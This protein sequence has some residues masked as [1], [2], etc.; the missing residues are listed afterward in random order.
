[1]DEL[2]IDEGFAE[3]ERAHVVE[4][5][6]EAFGRKLRPAFPDE[7]ICRKALMAT[8]RKDRFI[9]A[10]RGGKLLGICGFHQAGVGSVGFKWASLR[11]SISMLQFLRAILVLS[12]ISTSERHGAFTLDGIAEDS[13][14]RGQGVGTA[15]LDAAAAKARLAKARAVRLSV[16]NNNPR[17]RALYEREGFRQVAEGSIGTLSKFYGFREY[18]TMERDVSA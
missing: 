15:L 2:S 1:M 4:L 13:S 10:R 5:Y 18:I 16:V 14:A 6:L 3:N 17:A 9:V 12:V 7:A 11:G 8:M